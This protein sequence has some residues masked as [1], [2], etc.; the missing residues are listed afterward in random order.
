MSLNFTGVHAPEIVLEEIKRRLLEH[1]AQ[2]AE[3]DRLRAEVARLRQE[4]AALG[5]KSEVLI[6]Y[7]GRFCLDAD[8]RAMWAKRLYDEALARLEVKP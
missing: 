5:E 7:V 3:I 8:E 2:A 4:N 1:E 6:E